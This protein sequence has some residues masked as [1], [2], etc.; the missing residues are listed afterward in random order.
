MPVYLALF[1]GINVSGHNLIKMEPLKKLMEE[2]GYVNVETYIQSGNVV[3]EHP[4]TSKE[5]IAKAI[6]ILMY[7]EY[8]HNVLIFVL[9]EADLTKAIDGNP[10]TGRG[11]EGQ[12]AKKYFVAFL[13]G[14]PA[15]DGLDKLKKYHRGD[16]LYKIKENVMYMKLASSAADSKLTNV[17]IEN[18]LNIKATIRN[19]NTTLKMLDMMQNRDK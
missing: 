2:E 10:Y 16:D 8:G 6:E 3:F 19:W 4:E 13:A 7:R 12:G 9:D 15:G 18:K 5:K 11:P 1:R 17:F 14:I